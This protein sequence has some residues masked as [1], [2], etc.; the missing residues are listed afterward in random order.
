[1]KKTHVKAPGALTLKIFTEPLSGHPHK[2]YG[3]VQERDGCT[4]D[5]GEKEASAA[6]GMVFPHL[7]PDAS[8]LLY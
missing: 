7:S 1:M 5:L 4:L 3:A 8:V 2:T 6:M